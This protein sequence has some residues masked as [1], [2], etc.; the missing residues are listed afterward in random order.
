MQ[1]E[2]SDA[3]R[4]EMLILAEILADPERIN[5]MDAGTLANLVLRVFGKA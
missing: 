5:Y 3:D 2:V 4:D 1:I